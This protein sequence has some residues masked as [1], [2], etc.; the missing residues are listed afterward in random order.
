MQVYPSPGAAR[1]VWALPQPPPCTMAAEEPLPPCSP[2]SP[3][4]LAAPP[5]TIAS[6]NPHSDHSDYYQL[7][8]EA[9]RS[10]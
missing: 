8:F 6:L 10:G 9:V 1:G 5:R 2:M 7:I 4:A 3:D